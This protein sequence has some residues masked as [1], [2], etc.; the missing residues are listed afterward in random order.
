VG[1][2][3]GA[4]RRTGCGAGRYRAE[5]GGSL[6][7]QGPRLW[8]FAQMTRGWQGRRGGLPMVVPRTVLRNVALLAIR[9]EPRE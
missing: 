4:A 5:E 2:F 7:A 1:E 6:A 8:H 3:G 9:Y